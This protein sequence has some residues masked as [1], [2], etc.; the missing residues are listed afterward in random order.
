MK[1]DFIPRTPPVMAANL[2]VYPSYP[3]QSRAAYLHNSFKWHTL[4]NAINQCGICVPEGLHR[5][6]AD[7]EACRLLVQHIARTEV[8]P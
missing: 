4:T 8:E 6:R 2:I 3:S 5:A 1:S 7:A